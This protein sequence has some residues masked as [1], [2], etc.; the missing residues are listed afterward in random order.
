MKTAALAAASGV[1]AAV[2]AALAAPAQA[3][4]Q[5][6]GKGFANDAFSIE[7]VG[8]PVCFAV[9][10]SLRDAAVCKG[11]PPLGSSD[12]DTTQIGLIAAGGIRR[13]ANEPAAPG[14]IP[15]IGLVQMFEV[16]ASLVTHPDA[17]YAERVALD[18]TKTILAGLPSEARRG[19]PAIRVDTVD[20]LVVART[21]VDV[22]D[23]TPGTRAS[24]FAH[25][26]TATIFGRDAAYTVVWS[27]PASSSSSLA[28]LASEAT[29][30]MRLAPTQRPALR[31]APSN[32]VNLLTK[33][34]L[35]LGVLAL[36]G[37]AI[38]RRRR[39]KSGR[40]RAEL[41]PAHTD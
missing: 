6:H 4:G 17:P 34:L 7:L 39:N 3:Q 13:G 2:L 33:T 14:S 10:A 29:K 21:T 37:A 12:I 30:T 24:F 40:L 8:A 41:W 27:G 32:D 31:E 22:D 38:V 16:P 15:I 9:P 5:A 18:A 19:K 20:G 25:I 35:P 28:R 11:L 26:E 23:L 36:A 1:L